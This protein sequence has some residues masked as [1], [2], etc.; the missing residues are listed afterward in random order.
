MEHAATFGGWLT[1]YRQALHLQRAELASRVGC[2][3]VTLR[4][5]EGDERRPS[6]EM[7]ERLADVLAILPPQRDVFI[8]V[9]R[10]ELPIT[11]LAI[12][13]PAAP[14]PTNLP[15]PITAFAGREREV[16]GIQ[17]IL[18]RPEVRL[19]TITGAP[20]VGKT[21]LA[22]EAAHG[23]SAAFTDGVFFVAL[24]PLSDPKLVL[25]TIAH[26]LHVGTSG[27]QVLDERLGRYLRTRRVLLVLDNFEH[28]AAAAP[29]LSGLLRA[30][31]YLKLLVTSRVALE[32]SGEHRV[33]V[34]P[35]A[36]PPAAGNLRQPLTAAQAQERYP[37]IDLFIQRARAVNPNLVLTEANLRAIGEICRHL[38]G[39]PLAIELAAAH[40]AL[41]TPQELLARLDDRF[42][43]LGGGARDRPARHMTLE[44][45]I[46]WSYSLL[47][48]NDQRLFR[49]LSVFV[50]GCTLTAAQ[51]VCED[52]SADGHD[53]LGGIAALVAGSLL[54]RQ[55]GADG[56]SRYEMLETLREYALS[57]LDAGGEAETLR[58]QHAAY[59]LRLAEAAER[60][61]DGPTEW[62]W[63]ARLVAE[64]DNLR[65]ALRWALDTRD[66]ALALRLNAALLSFWSLCSTLPE[67]RRWITAALALPRPHPAP[68]LDPVEA[69]VLNVAGY[70]AAGTA[71]YAQA[72]G[73]FEQG[74]ALYKALDDSRGIA[75][76]LRGCAFAQMLRE[77]Y[78]TANQLYT[79]SR[80][81]C[82]AHGDAWGRAWSLYALAFLQLAQGDLPAARPALEKA[83]VLLRQENMAFAAFRALLALGDTLFEQGDLPGAEARYREALLL[84]RE[85]PL[86]TFITTGLEGL[87][88]IAGARGQSLRAAQLW[89][90]AAA[91]REVTDERRWP[92]FQRIYDR[93]VLA[94]CE[95]V[96][97]REWA[98]AWA[99]GRA[100][101]VAQ[102]V[103][104]ALES[105][106]PLP[107]LGEESLLVGRT[108]IY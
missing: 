46:D 76:S 43:L 104:E 55:V 103:A 92:V 26:A 14:S 9:A 108:L 40:T 34:L 83:L 80:K 37:A 15:A 100:L 31:P 62:E 57:R 35:L 16:A 90:A 82:E 65:A 41:F 42:A 29:Q 86:L 44:A 20:G 18:A 96:P 67:A 99:A 72:T 1:Q 52:G 59:Y 12:P 3:V 28:L 87:G 93:A 19:L 101:P 75:W 88:M 21:R 25:A 78:A 50:G 102:A 66:A 89:G 13:A 69:K 39:L 58:R 45:A 22:L 91:L 84:S 81:L 5:I 77:E 7:A 32:L 8:R 47:A 30:A 10:G 98:A 24:A 56:H 61:W 6:H 79:E 38:D 33:T 4:K 36:V 27:G 71:D 63:L 70:V 105:T 85:T 107:R 48:A 60:A 51:E 54:Q 49:R 74:L 73:Y 97:A 2:A 53:L 94:A 68:D 17:T 64:R 23:L 106:D 11:R 95:Q